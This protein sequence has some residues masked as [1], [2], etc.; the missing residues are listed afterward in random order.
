MQYGADNDAGDAQTSLHSTTPFQS[1]EVRGT[2]A[3][4]IGGYGEGAESTGVI[5]VG[6]GPG[7]GVRGVS[8]DGVGLHGESAK[9]FALKAWGRAGFSTAGTATVER[10]RASVRVKRPEVAPSS[11]VIATIQRDRADTYVRGV[12][13]SDGSFRILLNRQ[14]G[15]RTKVAYIVIE[16]LEPFPD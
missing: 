10:H 2:G 15:S 5:G 8:D 9:G 13:V 16:K 6:S 11:L 7:F 3:N 12:V 1:L 4:A 14:V